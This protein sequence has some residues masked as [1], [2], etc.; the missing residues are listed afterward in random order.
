MK[1]LKKLL[2][3]ISHS[4]GP[5]NDGRH[6]LVLIPVVIVFIVGLVM[7]SGQYYEE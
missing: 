2:P 1:L 7:I 4:F 3:N 5:E 6:L